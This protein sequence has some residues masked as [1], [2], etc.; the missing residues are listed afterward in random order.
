MDKKKKIFIIATMI[1]VLTIGCL[2]LSFYEPIEKTAIS[3]LLRAL[4]AVGAIGYIIVCVLYVVFYV[5]G[6]KETIRNIPDNPDNRSY[7]FIQA[8]EADEPLSEQFI[9]DDPLDYDSYTVEKHLNSFIQ[10]GYLN[11]SN[12]WIRK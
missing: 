10:S 9:E 7:G 5:A 2:I 3:D 12:V 11:E 1:F 4:F 8:A 6:K